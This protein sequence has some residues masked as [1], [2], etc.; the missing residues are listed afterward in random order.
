MAQANFNLNIP[1]TDAYPKL[2]DDGDHLGYLLTLSTQGSI[3]FGI[4]ASDG[5]IFILGFGDS[6]YQGHSFGE[7]EPPGLPPEKWSSLMY[8]L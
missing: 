3:K 2:Q 1:W 7:I 8:G 5:H 6:S 4:T